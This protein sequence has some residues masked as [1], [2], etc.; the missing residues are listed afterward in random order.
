MDQGIAAVTPVNQGAPPPV[1]APVESVDVGSVGENESDLI[2]EAL[3]TLDEGG[4]EQTDA[5][6]APKTP[7]TPEAKTEEEKTQAKL[8]KGFAKLAAEQDRH[9]RRVEKDRAALQAEREAFAAE[10]AENEAFKAARAKAKTSPLEALQELGWTYREVVDYVLADGK[11]PPEKLAERLSNESKSEIARVQAELEAIKAQRQEEQVRYEER[12][13]LSRIEQQ[14][15]GLFRDG[16][17]GLAKFPHFA[18][19]FNASPEKAEKL[20]TDIQN[21]RKRHFNETCTRDP[22]TGQIIKPGEIVDALPAVAYIERIFAEMQISPKNPGQPGAVPQTANAGAARQPAPKPLTARDLSVT[23]MPSDE[24]LQQ[25]SQEELEALS[26]RIY[27][28]G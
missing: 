1:A 4:G 25:M 13:D 27:N 24:E 22:K 15:R 14:T 21:L 7:E 17:D 23:S 28:G 26:L 9:D 16:G 11:I 12:Q 5:P 19:H 20:L 8:S 18:H 3:K 2:K 6:E 10:R